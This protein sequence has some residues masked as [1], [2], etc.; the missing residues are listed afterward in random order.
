MKGKITF[1]LLSI[2]IIIITGCASEQTT[3]MDGS[4]YAP[5]INPDDFVSMI[6]NPY[7]PLIPGTVTILEARDEE[8]V[9]YVITEVTERTRVVMGVT[10]VVV[11]DREYENG[12]LVEDTDDWFA[13]DVDGNVWYFG[14]ES[15]EYENGELVSTKG[16]WEAGVD[17]AIPG[18]IMQGKPSIGEPYFQEYYEGEAEDIGQVVGID[19]FVVIPFDTYE[20][21]VKVKEWNP[22]E[23]GVLEYK[24]YAEGIGLILEEEEDKLVPLVKITTSSDLNIDEILKGNF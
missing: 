10:C 17:G 15:K 1:I 5:V 16:S 21:C 20:N 24:Y 4:S 12:N 18:I 11:R 3:E 13:Q 14:E 23:P 6:D 7:Y 22:L 2:I 19:E 8:D 9:E